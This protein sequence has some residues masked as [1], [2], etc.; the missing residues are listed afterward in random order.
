MEQILSQRA[1]RR[2]SVAKIAQEENK[3][4]EALSSSQICEASGKPIN[5]FLVGSNHEK[6]LFV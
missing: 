4:I 1:R 6:L 5:F 3:W 2:R